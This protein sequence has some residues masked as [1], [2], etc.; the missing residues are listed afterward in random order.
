MRKSMPRPSNPEIHFN[1][2]FF[3]QLNVDLHGCA[4]HLHPDRHHPE[5]RSAQEV[6]TEHKLVMQG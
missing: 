4:E 6:S 5:W 2:L 3:F 1:A